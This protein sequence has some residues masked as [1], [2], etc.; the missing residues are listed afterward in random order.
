MTKPPMPV[1]V[2]HTT[3]HA[4]TAPS[5][6]LEITSL[7]TITLPQPVEGPISHGQAAEGICMQNLIHLVDHVLEQKT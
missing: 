4:R 7:Y 2:K 6:D 3:A 1:T 5:K